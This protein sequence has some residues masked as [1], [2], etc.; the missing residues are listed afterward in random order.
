VDS[1][2][3]LTFR[4]GV[5]VSPRFRFLLRG[6]K[7]FAG[8]SDLG[9]RGSLRSGSFGYTEYLTPLEEVEAVEVSIGQ[10]KK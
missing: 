2:F 1:A 10:P 8:D 6:K 3:T 7:T 4:T 9:G 5:D